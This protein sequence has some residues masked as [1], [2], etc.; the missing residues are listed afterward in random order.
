MVAAAVST[1]IAAQFSPSLSFRKLLNR[2]IV[3]DLLLLRLA[4]GILLL[5]HISLVTASLKKDVDGQIPNY[6][7]LPSKLLCLL[8]NV[9]LH[10]DPETD[11]VYA[12]MTL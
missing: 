7:N 2:A 9:T 8:H 1:A 12:Q 6:P 11:E 3:L 10:A 4:T 5:L